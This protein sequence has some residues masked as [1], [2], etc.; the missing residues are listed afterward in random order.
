[1][2]DRIPLLPVDRI[3]ITT[4]VDNYTTLLLQDTPILKRRW[5]PTPESPLA[6][7]GLSLLV[8]ATQGDEMRSVLLDPGAPVEALAHNW[9]VLGFDPNQVET[10]LLSHGHWDHHDGLKL[11]LQRRDAPLP[12]VLHPYALEQ[13][14]VRA[15]R[16]EKGLTIYRPPLSSQEALEN[17]GARPVVTPEP[18][19][20]TPT[21][22]S[23]GQVPRATEFEGRME[24]GR[25]R[26]DETWDD[27][28]LVAHLAGHGLVIL[29]G[30]AHAGIINTVLHAQALTGVQRIHAVIG[31]FHLPNPHPRA[32]EGTIAALRDLDPALLVPTHCTG[33]VAQRAIAQALPERFALNAVGTRIV[34]PGQQD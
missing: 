21:L 30:C 15:R 32:L 17:L 1:M 9:R 26:K 20:L 24:K 23:T 34:L 3:E 4:L 16:T 27:Q 11:F 6:S 12:V 25:W 28:A 5:W 10:L 22:L 18:Y 13:R 31:G 29:S 33:F 8:E 19:L 14:L 7:H 2:A